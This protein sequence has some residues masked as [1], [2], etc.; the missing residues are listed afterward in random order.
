MLLILSSNLFSSDLSFCLISTSWEVEPQRHLR[1]F[2]SS[3][4]NRR[5]SFIRGRPSCIP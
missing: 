3:F 4:W 5:L 1:S 2:P